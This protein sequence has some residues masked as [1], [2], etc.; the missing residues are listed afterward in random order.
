MKFK[1]KI[2]KI[3]KDAGY[4][5][6]IRSWTTQ[7][8]N[9][10]YENVTVYAG[11]SIDKIAQKRSRRLVAMWSDIDWDDNEKYAKEKLL[12]TLENWKVNQ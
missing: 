6:K 5:Y 10:L 11:R 4:N 7:C 12:K 1:D 9:G 8:E 2:K 3:I